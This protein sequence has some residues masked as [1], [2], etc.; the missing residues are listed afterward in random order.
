RLVGR[1]SR[2]DLTARMRSFARRRVGALASLDLCGYV[3]KSGSPSCGMARVPVSGRGSRGMGAFARVLLERMPLLPVVEETRLDDPRLRKNFLERV[4]AFRR[5]RDLLAKGPS[6]RGLVRFHAREKGL[7]RAHSP[8]N[9][10]RLEQ[11]AARALA[12]RYAA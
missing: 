8:S 12:E 9:T 2:T 1:T 6:A 3:L 5:L 4:H 7:L 11:L 10:R